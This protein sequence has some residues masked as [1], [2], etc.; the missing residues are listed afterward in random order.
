[1][2]VNALAV[3]QPLYSG[4]VIWSVGK[5]LKKVVVANVKRQPFKTSRKRMDSL[6]EKKIK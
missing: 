2:K 5:H 4:T 3:K 6:P 1:M